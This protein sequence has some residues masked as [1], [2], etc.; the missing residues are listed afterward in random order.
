[1]VLKKEELYPHVRK[2]LQEW[3]PGSRGWAIYD[4]TEG[5]GIQPDFLIEKRS[6]E[7]IERSICTVEAARTITDDHIRRID[8]YVSNLSGKNVS[9]LERILAVPSGTDT[10]SV[11]TGISI[12]HLEK[13]HQE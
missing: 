6:G 9:I 12:F 11:P 8:H 1:M 2:K 13:I 5:T 3:Y 7:N 4:R 10:S